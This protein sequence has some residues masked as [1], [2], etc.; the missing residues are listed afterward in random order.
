[1]TKNFRHSGRL[2]DILYALPMLQAISEGENKP[3]NLY[4]CSDTPARI[5][6]DVYHPSLDVMVNVAMFRYIQPLLSAQSYLGSV[7]HT[8]SAEIPADAINLDQFK[9]SGLNLK[10]GLISGWYRKAFGIPFSLEAPWLRAN[11]SPN[12][13]SDQIKYPKVLISRTTRFCNTKINYKFLDEIENVSFVGMQ[14]EYDDFVAR[15]QLKK[16]QHL[17]VR[18]ALELAELMLQ[19][20]IFI[21]NQ[22]SNF[23]IAEGLKIPRALEAFEPVPSATPIGGRCFEYIN[24]QFL[25]RFISDICGIHIE[26][27]PDIANGDFEESIK[28]QDDY[29]PP[30]KIKL[31]KFFGLRKKPKY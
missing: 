27:P 10:A 29:V 21:G 23:G 5:G 18:N 24:T 4:I 31:K 28:T 7:S 14:Y 16:I 3:V 25:V 12:V 20:D 8:P 30:V 15:H 22:S 1:M 9:S 26:A 6:K 11:L 17:K 2:G 19:A 13:H